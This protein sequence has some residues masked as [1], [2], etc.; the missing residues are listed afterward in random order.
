MLQNGLYLFKEN[1]QIF[2]QCEYVL[3]DSCIFKHICLTIVHV[4][5][6]QSTGFRKF[7]FTT[8]VF[9]STIKISIIMFFMS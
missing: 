9:I 4:K 7:K 5:E 8:L 2:Q 3:T 1:E 6:L